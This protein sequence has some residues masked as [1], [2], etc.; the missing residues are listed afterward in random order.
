LIE[1]NQRDT[2][3]DTQVLDGSGSD[4]RRGDKKRR[5]LNKQQLANRLISKYQHV[6]EIG[7]DMREALR[8]NKTFTIFLFYEFIHNNTTF[9][10]IF[11]GIW[12]GCRKKFSLISKRRLNPKKILWY[13]RLCQI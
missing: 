13:K 9:R 4:S 2:Q 1:L 7:K 8:V 6:S 3:V 11:S 12:Q 10:E 5:K